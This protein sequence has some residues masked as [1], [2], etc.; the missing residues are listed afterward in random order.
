MFN[1]DVELKKQEERANYRTETNQFS[2]ASIEYC[3]HLV[4]SVLELRLR[5]QK[6]I[7][8]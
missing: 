6:L 1:I 2:P 4:K 5:K 3:E 8:F 7:E